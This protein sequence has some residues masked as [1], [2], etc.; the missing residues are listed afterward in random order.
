[1][2]GWDIDV[3]S[4]GLTLIVMDTVLH[5]PIKIQGAF[6]KP[7]VGLGFC[8]AGEF[9]LSWMSSKTR[10][11][12]RA[13][14]SGFFTFPKD[15]EMTQHL[16]ADHL[17]RIYLMLEGEMLS[18]FT[19]GDEDY[20]SPVIK[21]FEKKRADRVVHSTTALMRTVLHQILHC[22]YCGKARHIY[23]ESKAME[24][25]S[26]KMAQLHPAFTC[27]EN[28]LKRS[29]YDNYGQISFMFGK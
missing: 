12:I 19:Q 20:F 9:D 3:F 16:P 2:G 14:Q 27:P 8:L 18:S 7:V 24:L 4:S 22:P 21:S 15:L 23:L 13:G 6:K 1:M 29:D 25:I 26:Y 17:L 28:E 11:N 10:S 5:K